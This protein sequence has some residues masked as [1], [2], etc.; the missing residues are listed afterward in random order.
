MRITIRSIPQFF[1]IRDNYTQLSIEEY[2]VALPVDALDTIGGG[3]II[4]NGEQKE[5]AE[6]HIS[7]KTEYLYVNDLRYRKKILKINYE[8][9][10]VY[11]LET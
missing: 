5:M 8:D 7:T 4:V 11:E 3:S 1:K 9:K 2:T 6:V 10:I